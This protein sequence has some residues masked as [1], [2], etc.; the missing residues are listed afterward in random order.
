M[1]KFVALVPLRGGSKSIPKKNIKYIAGK[2]LCAWALEAAVQSK[3]FDRII[4]ST[5]SNEIAEV[6]R[7]L[8]LG[9]EVLMRPSELATDRASTESVMLHVAQCVNFETLVTIQATSPLLSAEDLIKA[10]DIYINEELDSLLSGVKVKRF[11]WDM[12]GSPLNYNP[13]NRPMRQDF[14]GSIMENGA[15]YF[16]KRITLE[17]HG[18]RLGGKIG[19]YEMPEEL[20]VE[21]D[22]PS[23]WDVVEKLLLNQKTD[24]RHKIKLILVD[25]DGTLTDGGMYYSA[26]GEM[27]KKFNTKDA[28]GL[29][30]LQNRGIRVAIVTSENSDIVTARA[31]KLGIEHCYLG[32]KDK[33]VVLNKLCSELN[34]SYN[35]T[36]FIGDDINDI[37]C[38]K[39]VGYS[40][41]P[42]DAQQEVKSVS[43]YVSIF[44][45]GN[46][47][48][49][50]ICNHIIRVMF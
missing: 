6:I 34:I 21:I 39:S 47:A 45:A 12:N 4:V 15:F 44:M 17:K 48:V 18:C 33:M 37:E 2:P 29:E 38:M 10:R 5:D 8:G 36:G 35:E 42:V 49:R 30:I 32:I 20:A 11:F 40:A 26:S 3:I 22:E 46:G 41:C 13:L 23:D 16:T 50:D 9:V 43:S 28:K 7:G 14:S 31:R 19:I 1:N 24:N 27:L 25:V